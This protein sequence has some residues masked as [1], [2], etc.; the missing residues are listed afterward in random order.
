MLIHKFKFTGIVRNQ[1]QKKI[2]CFTS[3]PLGVEF[4]EVY[5]RFKNFSR[6]YESA[7]LKT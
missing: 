1:P 3:A 6:A 2:T 5:K 4:H 7:T